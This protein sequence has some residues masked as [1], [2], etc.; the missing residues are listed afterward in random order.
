[1]TEARGVGGFHPFAD[2][3]VGAIDLF[4]YWMGISGGV[5]SRLFLLL[6]ETC[7]HIKTI[8]FVTMPA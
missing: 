4:V 7:I 8:L 3:V 1:M 2:C 6:F 5:R